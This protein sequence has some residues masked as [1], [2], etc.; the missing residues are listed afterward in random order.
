MSI[1]NAL[2]TLA[3]YVLTSSYRER[4]VIILHENEILTP[5][6]L[7][8]KCNIRPNHISKTL[9]ELKEHEIVVCINESAKKGRLY[10]LTPLGEEVYNML[11]HLKEKTGGELNDL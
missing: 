5:K 7:A 11:P 3:A 1:D 9:R 6:V 8:E 2:L 10:L 4:A